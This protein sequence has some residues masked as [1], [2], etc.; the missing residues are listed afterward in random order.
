MAETRRLQRKRVKGWRLPEGARCVTRPGR[1]GNPFTLEWARLDDPDMSD[2]AAREY[3][4]RAFGSWL[5]DDNW[6]ALFKSL[7]ERRTWILTNLHTLVGLDLACYC[8]LPADGET[9]W[10]HAQVL[11]E[12]ARGGGR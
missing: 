9:D 11:L 8:P 12:L 5:T 6:A 3:A 4:V 7:N 1:F 2:L 10:C